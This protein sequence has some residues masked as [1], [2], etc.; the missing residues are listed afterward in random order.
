MV[1]KMVCL[2]GSTVVALITL[3]FLIKYNPSKTDS[4]SAIYLAMITPFRL[5]STA[6]ATCRITISK[7]YI[8]ESVEYFLFSKEALKRK[9]MSSYRKM[10]SGMTEDNISSEF[11]PVYGNSIW[12]KAMTEAIIRMKS[13]A[14]P[15][16]MEARK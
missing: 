2:S 5:Q 15:T 11:A 8:N 7:E 1:L 14:I 3:R 16:I 6:M 12:A 10:N 4:N 9:E 13:A